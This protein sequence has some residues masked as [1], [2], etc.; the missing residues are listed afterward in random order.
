MMLTD[1]EVY[2]LKW[3]QKSEKYTSK[4]YVEETDMKAGYYE[5][6]EVCADSTVAFARAVIEANNAKVLADLKPESLIFP[7]Y[8]S[9]AMGCG[10]EDRGIRDR[11]EAMQHGWDCAIERCQEAI[12]D[13]WY[14]SDQVSA[15]IQE[16]DALAARVRDVLLET[17]RRLAQHGTGRSD[18]NR[19]ANEAL[20]AIS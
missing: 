15:L 5:D 13:D 17:M 8:H 11:Y 10:L 6:V 1:E 12:P 2:T 19:I 3:A 7:E 4:R 14:P 16:R 20:K 9:E 18:Y